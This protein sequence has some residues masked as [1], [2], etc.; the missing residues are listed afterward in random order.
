METDGFH[1]FVDTVT[2]VPDDLCISGSVGL[3]GQDKVIRFLLADKSGIGMG[4]ESEVMIEKGYMVDVWLTP[5]LFDLALHSDF[6][7]EVQDIIGIGMDDYDPRDASGPDSYT[8]NTPFLNSFFCDLR[9]RLA[10][11]SIF[12]SG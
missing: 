8:K 3:G 11:C 10:G 4:Y 9:R 5:Q 12:L 6:L 1:Q 2:V 7:L